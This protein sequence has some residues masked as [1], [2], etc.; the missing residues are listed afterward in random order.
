MSHLYR[1]VPRF[2]SSII[3]V[4]RMNAHNLPPGSSAKVPEAKTGN[5]I[6]SGSGQFIA[7][8]SSSTT[9]K[10]GI[11]GGSSDSMLPGAQT[12]NDKTNPNKTTGDAKDNS[13]KAYE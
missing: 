1:F 13:D 11:G 9:T 12:A 4:S 10:T 8:N 6:V 7:T 2:T 3:Y 5:H